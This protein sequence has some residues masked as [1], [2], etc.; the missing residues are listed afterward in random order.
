LSVT[1]R[2]DDLIKTGGEKV[3]PEQV[4]RLLDELYSDRTSCVVGVPDAEWGESVVLVTDRVGLDLDEVR[5]HIKDH[6]P[7]RFAP[8]HIVVA[9]IPRTTNGKIRRADVR[10]IA[11]RALTNAD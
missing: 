6:L 4:E 8:K 1:G 11:E 5:G 3:W 7:A 10:V 9:D 2:L